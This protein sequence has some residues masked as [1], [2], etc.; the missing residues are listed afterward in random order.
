MDEME[1]LKDKKASQFETKMNYSLNDIID[2]SIKMDDDTVGHSLTTPEQ[3]KTNEDFYSN[4]T[5]I[6]LFKIYL[7]LRKMLYSNIK[8]N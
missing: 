4:E 2:D 7:E 8:L 6:N 5:L 1:K 3:N